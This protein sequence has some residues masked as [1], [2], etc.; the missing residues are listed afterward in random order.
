MRFP[1]AE[2]GAI[3]LTIDAPRCAGATARLDAGDH[4]A[5][6]DCVSAVASNLVR[7]VLGDGGTVGTP[8]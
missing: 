5:E 4:V 6:I 8:R 1:W 3:A 7:I 2:G